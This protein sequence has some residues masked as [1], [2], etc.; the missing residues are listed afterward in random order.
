MTNAA[1]YPIST[2]ERD[3]LE[4]EVIDIAK[5]LSPDELRV[6][7]FMGLR[8]LRI[9]HTKYGPLDLDADRR[10][11]T[12]EMAEE[13]ADYR[14]YSECREIAQAQRK[15]ERLACFIADEQFAKVDAGLDELMEVAP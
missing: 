11:W 4:S 13:I 3:S 8:M 1:A 6:F 15:K 5:Q 7:K 2:P 9:G 12:A 14:F 10:S